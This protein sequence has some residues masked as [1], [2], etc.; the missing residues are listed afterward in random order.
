[1]IIVVYLL[2]KETITVVNTAAAATATNNTDKKVT[3]KYCAPFTNSI[4]SLNNTQVR[5]NASE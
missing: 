2:F 4:S 5:S 1:M 3:C